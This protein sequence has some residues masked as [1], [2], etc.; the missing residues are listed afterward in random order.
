MA[1]PPWVRDQ[2][3]PGAGA[4]SKAAGIATDAPTSRT[5]PWQAEQFAARGVP[6]RIDSRFSLPSASSRSGR[7]SSLPPATWHCTQVAAARGG[8]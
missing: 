3:R 5:I 8:L 2:V 6:M 7:I 1:P 4:A